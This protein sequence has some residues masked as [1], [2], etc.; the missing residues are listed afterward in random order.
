[1]SWLRCRR[2]MVFFARRTAQFPLARPGHR[3]LRTGPGV[4][5]VRHTRLDDPRAGSARWSGKVARQSRSGPHERREGWTPAQGRTRLTLPAEVHLWSVES[6]LPF[7]LSLPIALD[8][9]RP[10][11]LDRR[12]MFAPG[13]AIERRQRLEPVFGSALQPGPL[14]LCGLAGQV[15]HALRR[16]LGA[17]AQP[18]VDLVRCR[19]SSPR[20]SRIATFICPRGATACGSLPAICCA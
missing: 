14:H 4:G 13:R 5:C 2:I 16:K 12:G 6:A 9:H 17:L 7:L 15:G 11:H 3:S 8:L 1:M 10:V 20:A 19:L 18:I